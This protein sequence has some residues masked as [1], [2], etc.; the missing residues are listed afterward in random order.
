MGLVLADD[1]DERDIRSVTDGDAHC[2]VLSD[3]LIFLEINHFKA[4]G[5]TAGHYGVA[6]P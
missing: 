5:I 3:D 2:G 1:E 4:T 6:E